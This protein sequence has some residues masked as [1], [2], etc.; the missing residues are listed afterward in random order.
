MS[1]RATTNPLCCACVRL[2]HRGLFLLFHLLFYARAFCSNHALFA[3]VDA[4]LS[5]SP[6]SGAGVRD[7]GNLLR[8][9][10]GARCDYV[11]ELAA[12]PAFQNRCSGGAATAPAGWISAGWDCVEAALRLAICLE[13]GDG[14]APGTICPINLTQPSIDG[15]GGLVSELCVAADSV[16]LFGNPALLVPRVESR[17]G[18]CDTPHGRADRGQCD[19]H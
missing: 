1:V 15:V 9:A 6:V 16:G 8:S 5:C 10:R 13:G 12:T 7:G 4:T 3:L 19:P 17:Y 2:L 18:Y 11:A 14:V